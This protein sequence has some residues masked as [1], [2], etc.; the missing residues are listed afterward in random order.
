LKKINNDQSLESA[1]EE[2]VKDG[3]NEIFD[4]FTKINSLYWILLDENQKD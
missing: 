4:H 3:L 1:T 2:Y